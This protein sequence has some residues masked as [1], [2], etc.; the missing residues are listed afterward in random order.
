MA[1]ERIHLNY[2]SMTS[3]LVGK[4][5]VSSQTLQQWMPKAQ[6]AHEALRAN[7]AKPSP[8]Q[9]LKTFNWMQLP[10][11]NTAPVL[12]V[13]SEILSLGIENL[14]SLG[15]GGSFL[16]NVTLHEALNSPYW[17]DFIK[18]RNGYPRLYFQGMNLDAVPVGVLL[19]N[20]DPKKTA[21]PVIS[22]SGTTTE[23]AVAFATFKNWVADAVGKGYEGRIIAI[24]DGNEKKGV[25]RQWVEE[26]N[27]HAGR[28]VVKSL[29]VPDGVGGRF[30][31]LSPVGLIT[32]ALTGI[33]IQEL[34]DG[35][36]DMY[37]RTI[38]N[39]DLETNPA[40]MY[41]LL[42]TI[43]YKELNKNI[44][45]M[46]P[47]SEQL[48][49]FGEWYVQNLAESLGKR[50]D[51]DGKEIFQGRTPIPSIGNR[52]LHAD[53]QNNVEGE[54]NK[55]VTFVGIEQPA[56]DF[57]IK[58]SPSDFLIG[59]TW[60]QAYNAALTAARADMTSRH[61]PNCLIS[62]PKLSPHTLGQLIF[63]L[64][65]ATYYEGVLENVNYSNQPGVEGYKERMYGILGR[66]GYEKQ[67]AEVSAFES[68]QNP[69]FII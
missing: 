32:A 48:K 49:S 59:K 43:A 56:A 62:L 26:I 40:L 20:L 50:F 57:T 39:D 6:K 38:E 61:R 29:P 28:E 15:I 31:V 4:H 68:N 13:A 54:F 67:A 25:L 55:V 12:S 21:I 36:A 27:R 60:S 33:K 53:Q 69:K 22:K 30:S 52:N 3:A 7:A 46:M 66:K 58:E 5:G 19:D 41:A 44:A 51:L 18:V 16:G 9:E 14:V 11:M 10:F 37:T 65:L 34:L 63:M 23:P 8:G 2:N 1:G 42:H 45:V 64:E 17:N 24:T 35:A 47:F